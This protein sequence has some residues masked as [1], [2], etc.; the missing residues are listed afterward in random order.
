MLANLQDYMLYNNHLIHDYVNVS[1]KN[2]KSSLK[3]VTRSD[4]NTPCK[5]YY[6]QVDD[7][8]FW[9]FFI[10][11]NGFHEFQMVDKNIFSIENTFKI[12][13]VHK[14]RENKSLLKSAKLKRCDVEGELGSGSNLSIISLEALCRV[15][16][17]NVM[18]IW[19]NKYYEIISDEEQEMNLIIQSPESTSSRKI[20]GIPL[21][22]NKSHDEKEQIIS[23]YSKCW[24]VDNPFKILKN[25]SYYKLA[26][27]QDICN[28]LHIPLDVDGKKKTKKMLYENILHIL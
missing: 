3:N 19:D 13:A 17:I 14:M 5:I 20:F 25:I 6:P 16:N 10:I 28:K 26:A 1:I 11:L 21:W 15:Y 9:C 23:H 22:D 4:P 27:L 8:L 7:S 24:K 12:N 2:A 18:Y